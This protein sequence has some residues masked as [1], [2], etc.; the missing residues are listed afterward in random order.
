M[1]S[2]VRGGL[3]KSGVDVVTAGSLNVKGLVIVIKEVKWQELSLE[4]DHKPYIR[5][6]PLGGSLRTAVN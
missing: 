4:S 1:R 5:S 2:T 6:K 3:R